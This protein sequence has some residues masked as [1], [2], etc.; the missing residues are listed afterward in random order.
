LKMLLLGRGARV[1]ML[2]ILV[3]AIG[4]LLAAGII[5]LFLGPVIMALAYELLSAWLAQ[6]AEAADAGSAPD[7][8]HSSRV[9]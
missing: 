8:A 2:V 4:G 6:T 1:P 7:R 5:G 3:G 9:P